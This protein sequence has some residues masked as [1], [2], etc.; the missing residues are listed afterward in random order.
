NRAVILSIGN[1][2]DSR[3]YVTSDAGKHWALTFVN[4]DPDAFY[5]CMTFF[6]DRRGLAL[7]DPVNGKFRIIATDDG[8]L[9]WRVV[10]S[11]GMPPALPGEFAFA[12]SGECLV[13]DHGRRAWFGTGGGA[14]AR[15]F[16]SDDGGATWQV[17]ATPMHSGPT[18]GIFALAFRG[19]Q[20]GL[21]VGGDFTTPTVAPA[22]LALTSDGGSSWQLAPGAPGQYRSGAAWVTGRDAIA[23]GPSGSDV[24]TD[25]G[26]TWQRFDDGSFDTVDCAAGAC[27]ASGEQGHAAY[28]VRSH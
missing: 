12:A 1:G 7:S 13:T 8:G 22:A 27:W 11:A 20:H 28:L 21:A 5:D 24:S 10:S 14:Q 26:R 4:D 2:G 9:T 25:Q 23:V 17:S 18:A 6:D 16:R 3:V 19:Q 15:V